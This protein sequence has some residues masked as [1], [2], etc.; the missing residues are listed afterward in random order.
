MITAFCFQGRRARMLHRRHFGRNPW[1]VRSGRRER[2]NFEALERRWRR[3]A[4]EADQALLPIRLEDQEA[5]HSSRV[6]AVV[7]RHQE[8]ARKR[9]EVSRRHP[10][11]AQVCGEWLPGRSGKS[12]VLVRQIIT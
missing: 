6:Q 7:R 5:G 9:P 3:F 1:P 4:G 10:D 11:P 12:S 2:Q 8:L